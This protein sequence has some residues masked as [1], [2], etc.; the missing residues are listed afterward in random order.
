MN[1]SIILLV[2][3]IVAP[4][5]WIVAGVA[6]LLPV[7]LSPMI[8]DYPGSESNPL[9]LGIFFSLMSFPVAAGV[10]AFC[11]PILAFFA[12]RTSSDGPGRRLQ[13]ATWAAALLPLVSVAAFIVFLALLEVF[14]DGHF[15]CR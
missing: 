11:T 10:S 2:V 1:R 9:T 13:Y 4:V 7:V 8:F 5:L 3:A 14:C 15:H 12:H 6:S